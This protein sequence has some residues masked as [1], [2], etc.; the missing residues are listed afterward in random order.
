VDG[1]T[2]RYLEAVAAWRAA[3]RPKRVRVLLVAESHVAEMPGDSTV[4]VRAQ[5]WVN[6]P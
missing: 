5:Q 1:E 6:R 2:A 4:V 3:W